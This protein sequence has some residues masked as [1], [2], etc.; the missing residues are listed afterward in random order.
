MSNSTNLNTNEIIKSLLGKLSK[1]ERDII[2]R[3]FGLKDSERETLEAVG[4]LHNLT[5][6]RIRQIENATVKKLKDL[7][8]LKESLV[9]LQEKTG[10]LFPNMAVWP[11]GNTFSIF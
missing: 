10:A 7:K 5:R 4:K 2:S 8:D 3:R 9:H 1:K 6:E 11:S